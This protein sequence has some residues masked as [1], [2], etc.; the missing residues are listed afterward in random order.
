[1]VNALRLTDM[2]ME[3]RNAR[4]M[5]RPGKDKVKG[6]ETW[7]DCLFKIVRLDDSYA[8]ISYPDIYPWSD[9][10]MGYQTASMRKSHVEA[11]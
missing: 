6:S 3:K 2:A 1:M 10:I 11:K 5:F 9:F 4:D 7:Y 8:P